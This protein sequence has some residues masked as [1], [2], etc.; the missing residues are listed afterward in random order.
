MLSNKL[1]VDGN[2]INDSQTITETFSNYFANIEKTMGSRLRQL[3]AKLSKQNC[4]KT[5]SF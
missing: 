4:V 3:G 2:E 5:F 1:I